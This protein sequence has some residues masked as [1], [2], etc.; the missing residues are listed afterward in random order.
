MIPTAMKFKMRLQ[1]WQ[2]LTLKE[3]HV[4]MIPF[5]TNATATI[6]PYGLATPLKKAM[7]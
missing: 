4:I 7:E 1:M 6:V 5:F 3:F 2:F